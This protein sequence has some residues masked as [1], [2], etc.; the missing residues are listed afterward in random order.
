M[1]AESLRDALLTIGLDC[2]VEPQGAVALLVGAD[3]QQ[4]ADADRRRE[5][6]RLARDHGFSTVALELGE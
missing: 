5:V 1:S 3:A 6:T 4:L 2:H